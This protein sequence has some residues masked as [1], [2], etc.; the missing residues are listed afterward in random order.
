M[1]Y[2][3]LRS[4]GMFPIS[5]RQKLPIKISLSNFPLIMESNVA[6]ER[7]MS[8]FWNSEGLITV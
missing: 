6:K 8:S 1:F 3:I 5:I 2:I 7:N 4:T